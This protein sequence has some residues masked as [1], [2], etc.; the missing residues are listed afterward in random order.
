MVADAVA[1]AGGFVGTNISGNMSAFLYFS[2]SF[3]NL[4]FIDLVPAVIKTF[5]FGFTIGFVG[6]FK[7]MN[8]NKGTESVGL[9][10][11]SAVV[12]SSIWIIIIDAIAVQMTSALV[13]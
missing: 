6:C 8:S 1:L 9:A 10:A 5:F 3:Q 2:K 13:Y 12:T 4:E 7:G 11:N